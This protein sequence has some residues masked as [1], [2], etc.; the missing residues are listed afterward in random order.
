MVIPHY[1]RSIVNDYG[2]SL[3]SQATSTWVLWFR[4]IAGGVLDDH[5]DPLLSHDVK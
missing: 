5:D 2:V 3:L 1:H 4:A